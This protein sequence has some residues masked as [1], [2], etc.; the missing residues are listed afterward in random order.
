MAPLNL[1]HLIRKDL[2]GCIHDLGFASFG[3]AIFPWLGINV[4]ENMIR[5]LSLIFEDSVESVAK[6]IATQ[7]RSLDFMTKVIP[8]NKIALDFLLAD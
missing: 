6:T 4:N 2:P 8:D 3:R 7:Q 5:N 1:H